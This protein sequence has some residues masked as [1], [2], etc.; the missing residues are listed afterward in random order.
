ML[1][2]LVSVF[3]IGYALFVDLQA[4]ILYS[5]GD[6]TQAKLLIIWGILVSIFATAEFFIVFGVTVKKGIKKLISRQKRC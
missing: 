4:L 5:S 3:L 2:R 6:F 1:A